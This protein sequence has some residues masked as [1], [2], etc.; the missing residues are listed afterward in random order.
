MFDEAQEKIASLWSSQKEILRAR[1]FGSNNE[2][3]DYLMDT[4]Y[5]LTPK[6]R[7]AAVGVGL[8]TIG[9]LIALTF[10]L[11]FTQVNGL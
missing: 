11:F 2:R 3:L 7:N 5:K 6:Q 1:V 4:F 10:V 9:G 8:G